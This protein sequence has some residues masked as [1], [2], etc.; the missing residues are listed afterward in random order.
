MTC[1]CYA[2]RPAIPEDLFASTPK[3]T[4]GERPS[5]LNA[6]PLP[7]A[8]R[9]ASPAPIPAAKQPPPA[10]L[11]PSLSS[12]SSIDPSALAALQQ[13]RLGS[14][15]SW[16]ASTAFCSS[17]AAQCSTACHTQPADSLLWLAGRVPHGAR[18]VGSGSDR[19]CK[20]ARWQR[21]PLCA[22]SLLPG[23]RAP[24]QGRRAQ[25]QTCPL[26]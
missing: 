4:A 3:A 6:A 8:P 18:R 10:A 17:L 24:A 23:R 16:L 25:L 13:V 11:K 19:L 21:G 15:L 14:R 2:V 7:L 12:K 1:V 22:S 5:V 26:R 9:T 20:G